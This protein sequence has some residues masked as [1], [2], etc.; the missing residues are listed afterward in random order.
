MNEKLSSRRLYFQ[1]ITQL[2]ENTKKRDEYSFSIFQLCFEIF[3]E[4]TQAKN[5]Y[6]VGLQKL[7]TAASEV[8]LVMLFS[9]EEQCFQVF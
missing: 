4:V 1:L 6:E 9:F 8:C 7:K 5:R 2:F 3:R